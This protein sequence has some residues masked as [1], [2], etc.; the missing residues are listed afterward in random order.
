MF[1]AAIFDMDGL[2]VD[3]EPLWMKAEIEL[4]S[5]LGLNL[6]EED[7]KKMQGVK[8]PDVI[9]HWYQVKP[10]KNL[11]LEQTQQKLLETVKQMFL[12]HAKLMPGVIQTLE[13]FRSKNIP[14]AIA[15]SSTPELIN[16]IVKKFQLNKYFE[17]THSSINEKHGKPY[18]DIYLTAAQRLNVEPPNCIVFED[19][20]NGVLA[21]KRAGMFV[22]A[23]PY[24]ENFN[25]PQYKIADLKLKSLEQWNEQ[26][27]EK[28]TQ[29][30]NEKM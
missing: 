11:S 14:M 16:I 9:K 13:F 20:I 10:W 5:S 2:L 6:T 8:I 28:I 21:A 23:V 25:D 15:S 12:E 29:C 18:P 22:I 3:T 17:F 19:S 27:W 4:F 26:I 30:S 7:C 1:K 24:P